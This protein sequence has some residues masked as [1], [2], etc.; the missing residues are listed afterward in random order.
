[1]EYFLCLVLLVFLKS[2]KKPLNYLYT[3]TVWIIIIMCDIYIAPYLARSCSKMLYNIII[4]DSDLF[5]PSTHLNSQGSIRRMLPLKAQ[6]ITQTHSHRI[7]SGTHFLWMSDPVATWQHCSSRNLEPATLRLRVLRSNW[8][9]TAIIILWIPSYFVLHLY[10]LLH[11]LPTF[12]IWRPLIFQIV[13]LTKSKF[14]DQHIHGAHEYTLVWKL[15]FK[16]SL[17]VHV[18]H[19]KLV[20]RAKLTLPSI[21]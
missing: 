7:L 20:C 6:G 18:V 15:S 2:I 5:P 1:M 4:P 12:G 8:A 11:Y 3:H 16:M 13:M 19:C 17:L 10:C 21:F 14:Q 9:I